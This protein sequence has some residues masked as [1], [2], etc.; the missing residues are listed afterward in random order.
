MEMSDPP[1]GDS[2]ALNEFARFANLISSAHLRREFD[3]DPLGTLASNG[4]NVGALPDSVRDFIAD[5]SFEELRLL[6][7][8]QEVMVGANLSV[9]TSYGTIAHL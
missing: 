7:R 9:P 5:L 6:A 4:V 1:Q 3:S 8:L 2:D